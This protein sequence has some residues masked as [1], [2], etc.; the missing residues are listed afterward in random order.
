MVSCSII[1]PTLNEKDFIDDCLESI[2]K[3]NSIIDD[4]EIIIIDGGSDD[5]T[6]ELINKWCEKY[7]FIKLLNNPK[8]ITPSALNIGVQN[9]IGKYI[10]RLDAHTIYCENYIDKLVEFLEHSP[11]D[12]MNVGGTIQ[13]KSKK[14]NF[15]SNCIAI[16]LASKFG[17]GN[18]FFRTEKVKK[19]IVVDTVP[20]GVFR[21]TIFD[22]IG[23]FNENE[24]RN[25]DLEFNQR[26]VNKG[27]KIMLLAG[28]ESIYFSRNTFK[29]FLAQSFD[30]GFIVMNKVRLWSSFHKIRHYVPFLF[31]MYIIFFCFNSLLIRNEFFNNIFIAIAILYF[32]LN[33]FFSS[34]NSFL[35]KK[36]FYFIPLIFIYF[37]LHVTYGLGSIYGLIDIFKF[38]KK[39]DI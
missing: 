5:G 28:V 15:I 3:N 2:I 11:S 35:I 19:N 27:F 6:I 25:E 23:L 4:S 10:V 32:L 37:S 17:V 36:K 29:S 14:N 1:I 39:K 31:L 21:K 18:S 34:I 24:P 8:K 26:I 38:T 16:V 33:I 13:T 9:A 20:F 22:E 12:V 7:E 30:N